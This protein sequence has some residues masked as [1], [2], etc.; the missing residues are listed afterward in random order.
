MCIANAVSAKA[1]LQLR[2]GCH[3]ALNRLFTP[4]VACHFWLAIDTY[5]IRKRTEESEHDCTDSIQKEE[6]PHA[7]GERGVGQPHGG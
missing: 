6:D 2:P 1:D 5:L 4:N 7:S 3:N